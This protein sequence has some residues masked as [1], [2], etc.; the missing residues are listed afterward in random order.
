[1]E[2]FKGT[3]GEWI[4]VPELGEVRS[5]D[6]GV[7]AEV[8][9]N[10]EEDDNGSLMSAAPELLKALQGTLDIIKA[11]PNVNY[12]RRYGAVTRANEAIAKALRK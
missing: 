4:Y 2:E 12:L 7:L 8:V 10:G 3:S 11:G 1:M 9:V 6:N 5:V